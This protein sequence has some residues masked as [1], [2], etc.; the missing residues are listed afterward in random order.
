MSLVSKTIG[1]SQM[2]AGQVLQDVWLL[3]VHYY[4]ED[5]L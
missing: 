2:P 4:L 1:Q 3:V 5:A